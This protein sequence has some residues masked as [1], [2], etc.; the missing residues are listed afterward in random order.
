[1]PAPGQAAP[2]AT[3]VTIEGHPALAGAR[4]RLSSVPVSARGL[5]CL[6]VPPLLLDDPDVVQ[7]FSFVATRGDAPGLRT[8]VRIT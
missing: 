2:L 8:R 4:A 6:A 3:G 1:V 7:P 5:G